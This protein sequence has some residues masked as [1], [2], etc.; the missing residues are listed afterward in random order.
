MLELG[1]VGYALLIIFVFATL[2]AIGRVVDSD[3][4]RGWSVLAIALYIIL[5]G[6]LESFWM[7]GSEFLWVAFVILALDIGRY[8]HPF[9]QRK[10]TDRRAQVRG[11]PRLLRPL[12]P[13]T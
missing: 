7:R 5:Y 4:G 2:H 9:P 11:S 10:G 6:F 13:P 8:W 3:R 12:R 1:Y